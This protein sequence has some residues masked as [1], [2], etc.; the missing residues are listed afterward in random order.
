[1][2]IA[3]PLD[4]CDAAPA[5]R[6]ARLET[7]SAGQADTEPASDIGLPAGPAMSVSKALQMLDVFLG[8]AEPLSLSDIG[9]RVGLP[10]STAFRL[11]GQ[12][13]GS[14]YVVRK[15]NKYALSLHLF[16]LGN[17]VARG[18]VTGLRQVAAPY[19]GGLFQHT[20]FVVNLAVL[21]GGEVVYVDKIH[22]PRAPRTPSGVGGRM[23]ALTT[24]LGKS[25]LAFSPDDVVDAAFATRAAPLTPYTVVAPGLLR[26]QFGRVREQG[27]AY[28]RE[29]S[30][31]G[32][33][34]VGAPVLIDGQPI[35]AI[36]VSGPTGR[37]APESV[38]PLVLRTANLI[39]AEFKRAAPAAGRAGWKAE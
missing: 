29:E 24:A 23:P 1:M 3:Q 5:G 36:S 31:L 21:D 10:K 8:A 27:V 35:A 18:G 22:G 16:E 11:L 12:L 15:G 17:H 32:L 6:R 30:A 34:C 33:T 39:A 13:T 28:D 9:R 37:F 19:L 26:N 25:V 4:A 7:R 38:A 2:A 14:G 20:G